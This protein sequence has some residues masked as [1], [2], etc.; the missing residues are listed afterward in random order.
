MLCWCVDFDYN[1]SPTVM[2]CHICYRPNEMTCRETIK[3]LESDREKRR[4]RN[5]FHHHQQQ[6]HHLVIHFFIIRLRSQ[7]NILL[8]KDFWTKSYYFIDVFK[9][10]QKMT[11]FTTIIFALFVS[12]V[13]GFAPPNSSH[14]Q[15]Q[16]LTTSST[17]LNVAPTMVVY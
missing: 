15:R 2:R 5:L 9:I 7:Q 14:Q 17:E 8:H 4:R 6:H 3:K 10:C 13:A 12:F 16:A 1:L 11:K